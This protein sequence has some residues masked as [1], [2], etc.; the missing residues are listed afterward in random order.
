M[1][2]KN[3]SVVIAT[4]GGGS[5]KETIESLNKSSIV[6]KEILICI[7]EE[8]AF[9]VNQ[10]NY[11]NIQVL[12]TKVKGQVSQRAIGF[13]NARSPFVLQLDD[14]IKL[15]FY[16]LE[17]LLNLATSK[18]NLAVGPKL[19]DNVTKE[20]HGFLVPNFNDL[21]WFNK[22]FYFVAN[23][24]RGYQPGKISKSG[25]NFGL[26]EFPGTFYDVDWLSGG[27]LLHRKENLILTNFYPISGKAYA[28]DLFHSRLL[29]IN[30]IMLVRS[31]DAKCYVD[32]S[33]SKG[34]GLLL[35]FRNFGKT[36]VPMKIFVRSINGKLWRLYLIY[37][38]ILIRHVVIL[39]TKKRYLF[40]LC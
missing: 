35:F 9:K 16:C 15:D 38:F 25:I 4:L 23:G 1:T 12:K 33:S 6:P 8:Y 2:D 24:D 27:C 40:K 34:G 31:G 5:L 18:P 14:D 10:L 21:Q 20:Y 36:I 28:E 26:P 19:F 11:F 39:F 29:R 3:I 30:E 32:F 17:N 22:L 7:P 37:V 13:Q